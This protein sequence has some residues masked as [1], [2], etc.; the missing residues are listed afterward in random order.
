MNKKFGIDVSSWQGEVDWDKVK[1]QVDFVIIRCGF[2]KKTIDNQAKRNLEMCSKLK[3]PFGAYWFSY[4]TS[5]D[6]AKQEANS[7]LEVLR[8]YKPEYPLYFDFE[9]S[10]FNYAK[11]NGVVVTNK[12]LNEMATAFCEV[13]EDAGYY[14]GIYANNDYITR[15]YGEDI[16]SKYDLWY[17]H[18]GVSEPGRMVN[19]WQYTDAGK[20][21]GIVGDV[22]CNFAY[23]DYPTIMLQ[24]GLN[25]VTSEPHFVCPNGCPHC[26]HSN[27]H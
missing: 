6:T 7:L 26:P 20:I 21:A 23:K 25:G 16:F 8:G 27:K 2:G 15:M 13:L 9:Y 5:V 24:N 1:E 17:A 12:L 18:W 11:Q 3:I 14:A 10:S 19:M 22:D 4:A